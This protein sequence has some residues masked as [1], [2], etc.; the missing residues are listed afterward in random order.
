MNS[1]K[2]DGTREKDRERDDANNNN[3]KQGKRSDDEQCASEGENEAEGPV[4]R[5]TDKRVN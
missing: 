2:I 3:N 5:Q 4:N 1:W